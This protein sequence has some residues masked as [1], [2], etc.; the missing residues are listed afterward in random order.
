MTGGRSAA[1]VSAADRPV[2][3]S[4]TEATTA[5]KLRRMDVPKRQKSDDSAYRPSPRRAN[6]RTNCSSHS[7]HCA[8]LGV[9]AVAGRRAKIAFEVA[10]HSD[11]RRDRQCEAGCDEAR[12][13]Q[14]HACHAKIL[15]GESFKR[16]RNRILDELMRPTR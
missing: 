10:A 15:A 16:E 7:P 14:P 4:A 13:T 6:C 11:T 12:I 9:A 1:L 2:M 3:I 8:Q 5:R